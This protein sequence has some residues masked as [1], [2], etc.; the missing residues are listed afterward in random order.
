[1]LQLSCSDDPDAHRSRPGID[2]GATADAAG[3]VDGSDPDGAD[4]SPS[5]PSSDAGPPLP[6][7][8]GATGTWRI[9]GDATVIEEKTL[10]VTGAAY[11]HPANIEQLANGDLIIVSV[12]GDSEGEATKIV[13]LLSHDQ[14]ATWS[15]PIDVTPS[16]SHFDPTVQ[17][18][19]DGDV[20]V[21]YYHDCCNDH[22]WRVSRDGGRTWGPE[23]DVSS[24]N[25]ALQAGE[26]SNCLRHPNGDWLCGWSESVAN[27]RGFTSHIPKGQLGTPSAWT[28]H[29][30]VD[31]FWN[32]DF[33]VLNPSNVVD[34]HYQEIVAV[35][36]T[37]FHNLGDGSKFAYSSN[38]GR[39]F[40]TRGDIDY[41]GSNVGCADRQ[42]NAHDAAQTAVS[43]DLTGGRL[44]GWHVL[45]SGGEARYCTDFAECN[46]RCERHFMR[47]F[48]SKTAD[49]NDWREMLEIRETDGGNENADCSIIQSQDRML[50]L[51][52]TGRGSRGVRY[53]K[54][55]PDKLIANP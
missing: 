40:Q 38:G 18:E 7:M 6:S 48:I 30:A 2:A 54:I 36:R 24:D 43:L 49:S 14:G 25:L 5:E 50:H 23:Q 47:V 41:V 51:I 39:T 11:N 52:W 42:K 34:G 33:M 28:K 27:G 9:N 13:A 26:Q 21:F 53:M 35:M 44:Q 19:D 45:A 46:I 12:S 32:P 3:P 31:Q 16:G 4:A 8:P 55:D 17:Q 10:L 22:R 20:Y 37:Q 15:A 29:F 1:M